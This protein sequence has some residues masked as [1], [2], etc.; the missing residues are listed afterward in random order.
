MEVCRHDF[1]LNEEIGL[2]CRF[3][4]VVGTEIRD[5]VPEF[6]SYTIPALHLRPQY[7]YDCSS[8][9]DNLYLTSDHNCLG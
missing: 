9:A 6:V 3:C 8:R 1:R 4:G 7:A 2:L 5:I